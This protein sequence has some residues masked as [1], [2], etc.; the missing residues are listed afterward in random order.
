MRRA[1]NKPFSGGHAFCSGDLGVR[2]GVPRAAVS[3]VEVILG[4]ALLALL[5]VPVLDTF[6]MAVRQTHGIRSR[7]VARSIGD[8]ALAQGRSFVAAGMAAP[9][10]HLVLTEDIRSRFGDLADQLSELRVER[11]VN[12]LA[13]N[14]EE[15]DNGKLYA[16]TVWVRWRDPEITEPRVEILEAME[17]SEV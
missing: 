8:W 1:K 4:A 16:I 11:S 9:E 2:G 6:R 14:E 5:L 13:I 12:P 3:L 7:V 15:D 10:D 17:R